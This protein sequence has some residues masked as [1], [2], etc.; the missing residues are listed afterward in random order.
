MLPLVNQPVY[1][2]LFQIDVNDYPV[3]DWINR[4]GFYVGC[5]QYLAPQDL[6]YLLEVLHEV[7]SD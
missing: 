4:N 7:I 2:R 3:A 5:H 1:Q 6:D